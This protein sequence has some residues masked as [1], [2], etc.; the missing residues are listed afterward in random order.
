MSHLAAS[1]HMC[2]RGGSAARPWHTFV[3]LFGVCTQ[4][5]ISKMFPE[6]VGEWPFSD[7]IDVGVRQAKRRPQVTRQEDGIFQASNGEA[8]FRVLLSK[9][10]VLTFC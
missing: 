3:S 6:E 4:L 8:M 9:G 5:E 2:G 1:V 10:C 7:F